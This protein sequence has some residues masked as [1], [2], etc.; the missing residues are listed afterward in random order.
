M[1][2]IS[3]SLPV[4]MICETCGSNNVMH[5]AWAV[6]DVEAQRWELGATFDYAHCE[7]CESE[8]HIVEVLM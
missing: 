8:T 3:D 2:E 4:Q 5:D 7:T 1:L 6:W